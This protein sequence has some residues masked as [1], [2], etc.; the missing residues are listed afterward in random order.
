MPGSSGPSLAIRPH[1]ESWNEAHPSGKKSAVAVS[2]PVLLI[3]GGKGSMGVNFLIIF[4][5]S[6]SGWYGFQ[7]FQSM[8]KHYI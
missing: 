2:P 1:L 6:F 8:E 7:I 4:I 3:P 5:C